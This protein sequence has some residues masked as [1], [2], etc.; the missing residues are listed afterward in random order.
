[1]DLTPLV[2]VVLT[3]VLFFMLT[4]AFV[5]PFGVAVDVPAVAN[6]EPVS[7]AVLEIQI[8]KDDRVLVGGQAVPGDQ[9]RKAIETA[10]RTGRAILIT[11]D[12][13]AT[14]GRTLQVWDV[15]KSSGARSV[16]IRTEWKE[17]P[18]RRAD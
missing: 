17:E 15:C 14:L 3:L 2:D 7:G 1:M 11:G 12:R 16:S 6:A 5:V 8:L 10:A 13:D 4:S 9:V 18:S